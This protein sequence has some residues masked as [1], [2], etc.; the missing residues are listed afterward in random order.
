M[1]RLYRAIIRIND[2]VSERGKPDKVYVVKLVAQQCIVTLCGQRF[3]HGTY[4]RTETMKPER[5][6]SRLGWY[7]C[8]SLGYLTAE[9]PNRSMASK[10]D[11]RKTAYFKT[12]EEARK[13][14]VEFEKAELRR[15]KRKYEETK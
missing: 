2:R 10:K 12:R 1:R 15:L 11:V 14:I 13:A 5:S 8:T 7:V 9:G 4:R 6:S 3:V